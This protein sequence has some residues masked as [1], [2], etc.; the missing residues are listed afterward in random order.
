MRFPDDALELLHGV[1]PAPSV[2]GQE[3]FSRRVD[4]T[5]PWVPSRA[6]CDILECMDLNCA[7][8]ASANQTIVL[9]Q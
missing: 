3:F 2:P 9:V 5:E 8:G 1:V 7:H 6:G 4:T